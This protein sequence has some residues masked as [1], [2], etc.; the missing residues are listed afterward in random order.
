MIKSRFLQTTALYIY[1]GGLY[2]NL[3]Q[4]GNYTDF[5]TFL[6]MAGFFFFLSLNSFMIALVPVT[7]I[8]PT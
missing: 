1:V 6:A 7:L 3:T 4:N 8:F 2:Y 5:K